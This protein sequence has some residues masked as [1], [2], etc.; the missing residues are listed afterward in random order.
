MVVYGDK[1][2]GGSFLLPPSFFYIIKKKSDNPIT[3][4]CV[5][6][7]T[8]QKYDNFLKLPNKKC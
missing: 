5:F 2:L 7:F 3:L 1:V 6:N 4:F 8:P